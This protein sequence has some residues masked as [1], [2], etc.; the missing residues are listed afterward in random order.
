MPAYI[1]SPFKPSPILLVAGKPEYLW[2]AFNDR[3]GPTT[4]LV[5]SDAINAGNTVTVVFQVTGGNIP[6]VG[7]LVTIVG[8]AN[9]SGN[10]NVT[11]ASIIGVTSTPA[12]VVTIQF[13]IQTP[14]GTQLL[15]ADS[16]QVIIPQPETSEALAN[17]ASVPVAVPFQNPQMD[18]GRSIT[19]V[20][21]LPSLPTTATITLQQSVQ[22]NDVEYADIA[23][24]VSVAGG[25]STGGQVTAE[26]TLG[27]FYRFNTTGVTGGTLPSIIGKIIG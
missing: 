17:G 7:A 16:G 3:T 19:A 24:V 21:S 20:V 6:V 5:I 9:A 2:G 25:V 1:K 15:L 10:I 12:G 23:T 18:Q 8:A 11:N 27:R 13:Q 14:S 26:K 22:D 4:G